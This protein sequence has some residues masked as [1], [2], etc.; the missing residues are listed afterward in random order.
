M[1][2][3]VYLEEA[4]RLLKEKP[5]NLI[6]FNVKVNFYGKET[7]IEGKITIPFANDEELVKIM[8]LIDRI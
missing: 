5:K 7:D 4:E 1:G 2:P 3:F 6:T 8:Q